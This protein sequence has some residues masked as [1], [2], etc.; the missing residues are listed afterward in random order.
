M[1]GLRLSVLDQSPIPEGATGADALRNTLDLAAL[2]DEL[3]YQRYWVA[4]HHATP[5]LACAAPEILIGRH[6]RPHRSHPRGQRRRDAPALQ[7]AEG[8]RDVQP[9]RGP[10]PRAHRPRDRARARH[11]PDDDARAAARPPPR[12]ARRL[13][14]AALR[15]ARPAGGPR[16]AGARLRALPRHA[17]RAPGAPR[18]LAARLLAAE[19]DLGRGAGPALL[20]RRLHQPRGSG[21]SPPTTAAAS[22][23]PSGWPPR[24]SRSA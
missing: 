19:R 16:P 7:P 22:S 23:T 24:S 2:A 14:R 3:G 4:E 10:A 18:A 8:G 11:R 20:V 17:A 9:A 15:V 5:A 6:R 1:A 21:A 12:R 13:H